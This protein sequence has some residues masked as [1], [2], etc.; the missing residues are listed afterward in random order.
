MAVYDITIEVI[1]PSITPAQLRSMVSSIGEVLE[2]SKWQSGDVEAR[3]Q[4]AAEP[5]GTQS[6]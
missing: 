1:D 3:R 2:L 4:D 5:I 6:N